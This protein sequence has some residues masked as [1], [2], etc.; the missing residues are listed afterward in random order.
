MMLYIEWAQ[1]H[2]TMYMYSAALVYPEE[3]VIKDTTEWANY[4]T[5]VWSLMRM[6]NYTYDYMASVMTLIS[7]S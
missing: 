6:V 4:L 2:D 7:Y 3:P 1:V 5:V